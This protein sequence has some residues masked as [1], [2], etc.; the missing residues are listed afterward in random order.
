MAC[1]SASGAA[2][3]QMSAHSSMAYSCCCLLITVCILSLISFSLLMRPLSEKSITADELQRTI[4]GELESMLSVYLRSRDEPAD[5]SAVA[6]HLDVFLA[7][8][9]VSCTTDGRG[10]AENAATF[11]VHDAARPCF[12]HRIQLVLKHFCLENYDVFKQYRLAIAVA[13]FV[14][15]CAILSFLSHFLLLISSADRK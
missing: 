6:L 4:R 1:I 7:Q 12:A 14:H 2:H 3:P 15:R 13:G 8:K 11:L 9:V 10:N 5:A